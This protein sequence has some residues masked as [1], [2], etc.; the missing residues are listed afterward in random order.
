MPD[1]TMCKGGECIFKQFCYRFTAT[2]DIYYQSYFTEPPYDKKNKS[3]K[4]FW[5][6]QQ[7]YDEI[8]LKEDEVK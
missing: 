8:K 1:I 5:G 2:P 4:Y 6:K 3:C 7:D